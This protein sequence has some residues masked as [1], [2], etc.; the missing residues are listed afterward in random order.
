MPVMYTHNS[1]TSAYA[2]F[3]ERLDV[4]RVRDGLPPATTLEA[5]AAYRADLGDLGDLDDRAQRMRRTGERF[6]R[7][8]EHSTM[9]LSQQGIAP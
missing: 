5:L 1:Q 7:E 2:A 3:R 8:S 4:E 9:S 6:V